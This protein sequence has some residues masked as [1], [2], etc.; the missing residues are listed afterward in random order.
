M[1]RAIC[2]KQIIIYGPYWNILQRNKLNPEP[3]D[4]LALLNAHQTGVP[5]GIC[6]L[7]MQLER[8]SPSCIRHIIH[9][10]CGGFHTTRYTFL[11][12]LHADTKRP[13]FKCSWWMP[14]KEPPSN[15]DI[16]DKMS[17]TEL[18]GCQI[19]G[20]EFSCLRNAWVSHSCHCR[21]FVCHLKTFLTGVSGD[22]STLFSS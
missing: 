3:K 8:I 1:E 5:G 17:E 21:V 18:M 15:A 19:V 14:E 9:I 16:R 4:Q 12:Q 7:S 22:I 6:V 11:A 10:I 13:L 2:L 20:V